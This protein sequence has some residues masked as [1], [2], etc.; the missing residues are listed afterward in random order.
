MIE[1]GPT[2]FARKGRT[3]SRP[4]GEGGWLSGQGRNRPPDVRESPRQRTASGTR[5]STP[6]PPGAL[7][8]HVVGNAPIA[9]VS[10]DEAAL[11]RGCAAICN[12]N[13]GV[14]SSISLDDRKPDPRAAPVSIA[15]F[16]LVK[17]K[18]H[19]AHKSKPSSEKATVDR[20]RRQDGGR[21]GPCG[22]PPLPA[23]P[24]DKV[25]MTQCAHIWGDQR[26]APYDEHQPQSSGSTL[27]MEAP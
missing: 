2:T 18:C 25:S 3:P 9:D 21:D 12:D 27:T 19:A 22:R 10:S 13:L 5:I 16:E 24:T 23:A 1:P 11:G 15:V 6:E 8:N 26:V 14:F 7:G 17:A 4:S 20:R